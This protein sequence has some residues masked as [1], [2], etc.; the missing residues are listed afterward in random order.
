MLKGN[1]VISGPLAAE[2]AGKIYRDLG[3]VEVSR[4]TPTGVCACDD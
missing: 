4:A 2:V 1:G 3:R